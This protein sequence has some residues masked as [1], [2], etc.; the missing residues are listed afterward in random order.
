MSG[1]EL[2]I[3]TVFSSP[4]KSVCSVSDLG[5]CWKKYVLTLIGLWH[6]GFSGKATKTKDGHNVRSCRVADKTGS[7]NV[8]VWDD[9]GEHLQSGDII[10]FC[11][12]CVP[13][14]IPVSLLL[15]LAAQSNICMWWLLGSV[16]ICFWR[17]GGINRGFYGTYRSM[18]GYRCHSGF[19]PPAHLDPPVQIRLRIW[20]P[21]RGFG[22]P[23]KK[24]KP[25]W[26]LG[27]RQQTF[28][29]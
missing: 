16:E 1:L 21:F 19:G 20:T 28:I 11:K 13:I 6:A 29:M 23:I 8:S 27:I 24:C 10:K 17:N 26:K 14:Y 18:P 25:S 9:F 15:L 7:I 5:S 22:P 2:K 4:W 3:W 12:G